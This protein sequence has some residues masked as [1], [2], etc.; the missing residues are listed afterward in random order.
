MDV[1]EKLQRTLQAV[2]RTA[3]SRMRAGDSL[4]M[5]N[6]QTRLRE[7]VKGSSQFENVPLDS[8]EDALRTYRQN[9]YLKGLRQIR[10]VCYGSTQGSVAAR[11]IESRELFEKL[12]EY[13]E[14]Y[15]DRRR[16]F[17]KLYRGLLASYFSYDPDL[18][19]NTA[20][21]RSN[22]EVLRVFLAKHLASFVIGEF[23][24][25]WLAALAKYPDLLGE[26]PGCAIETSFLQGDWSVFNEICERLELD[27]GAWLVRQLVMAQFM[28]IRCMDDATFREH[29]DSLLLFL[30]DY[31]LYA[32]A[33]LKVLLDRYVQ[34]K[35]RAVHVSLRNFAVGLW[36]NPWLEVHQWQCGAEARA[37]LAH[38]LKRQLLS[39]FFGV[40]SNDDPAHQRRY[41]FWDLYSED[42][43]GMYFALGREAYA[44]G[45][46]PLYK[47][48]QHAKG[49]IAKLTDEK[50]IVHTCIMQFK[51]YHVVELN[52]ENNVAYFYD[53]RQGTPSFYFAKG[54]V[55]IG[56]IGVK[57]I[58]QG[59]DIARTSKPLRHQ[60]SRQ[61]AW[62]GE[63]AREMGET[64]NA[65]R[66]FCS[67]YQCKY[68]DLREKN[69]CQWIRFNDH[70]QF[71]PEVWSVLQGWGFSR[72][73]NAYFRITYPS[74]N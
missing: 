39:E 61:L 9:K 46:M 5:L 43:T 35:D 67:K 62:E 52:R 73:E 21:G 6:E 24:P 33:G 11:L 25:D 38:W 64:E 8:I 70:E 28:A 3:L 10:L 54:W 45:N 50:H 69:G 72:D 26:Q 1:L 74:L 71:G 20:V 41:H 63:F 66:A 40:L 47:F 36:G 58:E 56:A 55:D 22:R 30:N 18:P 4:Q 44:H 51:N 34:C 19:E 32:G 15:R 59:A 48:R 12:L 14:H 49:L 27:A 65:I 23:T 57:D 7:W 13:V 29:L 42:L 2:N 53:I 60:D 16:T 31:P 37:M 17:R 68:E